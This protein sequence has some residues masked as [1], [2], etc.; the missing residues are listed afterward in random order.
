MKELT[1]RYPGIFLN[2]YFDEGWAVVDFTGQPVA[3]LDHGDEHRVMALEI[4]EALN[5]ARRASEIA[6]RIQAERNYQMHRNADDAQ[7]W[8]Q[9]SVTR[10]W[11]ATQ[12]LIK[13]WSVQS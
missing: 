9:L 10:E 4:A 11:D 7:V 12:E 13:L 5:M 1:K 8:E 2:H 3:V 6:A